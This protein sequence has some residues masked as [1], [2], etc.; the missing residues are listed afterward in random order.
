L[1]DA[2]IEKRDEAKAFFVPDVRGNYV[3]SLTV[4]DGDA[5]SSDN[6][7]VTVRRA[8]VYGHGHFKHRGYDEA[9]SLDVLDQSGEIDLSSWVKYDYLKTH[10]I[11]LSIQI[12]SMD[13]DGNVANIAGSISIF[14]ISGFRFV[15]TV[16]DG[17][18]DAF[19]VAIFWPNGA[20]LYQYSNVIAS[21]DFVVEE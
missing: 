20:L 4:G 12:T 1:S 15:V 14:G 5:F 17:S 9:L 7:A 16:T 2:D 13:M 11:G 18:S 6:A 3:L 10:F 8:H 21:G 19:G